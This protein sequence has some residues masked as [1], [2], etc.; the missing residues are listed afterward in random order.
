MSARRSEIGP[1]RLAYESE[2]A[3]PPEPAWKL[4]AS[5]CLGSLA[6]VSLVQAVGGRCGVSRGSQRVY[7]TVHV[8][9]PVISDWISP[10]PFAP[11]A[12]VI[13]LRTRSE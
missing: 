6:C 5:L 9:G 4:V 10:A 8:S 13:W 12:S 1:P 3:L 2:P 7:E 11:T